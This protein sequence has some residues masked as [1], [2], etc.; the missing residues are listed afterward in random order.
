MSDIKLKWAES[1][2]EY[3]QALHEKQERQMAL[4]K[5]LLDL[6]TK[7]HKRMVILENKHHGVVVKPLS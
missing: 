4:I 5:D 6:V 1:M 2:T 7:L 3:V